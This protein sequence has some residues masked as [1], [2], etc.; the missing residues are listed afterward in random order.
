MGQLDLTNN[1]HSHTL[2]LQYVD[3]I[4]YACSPWT[5]VS[6]CM[7]R[8]SSKKGAPCLVIVKTWRI[9]KNSASDADRQVFVKKLR[10]RLFQW[11]RLCHHPFITS[12]QESSFVDDTLPVVIMPF[13]VHGNA[14]DFIA[15]NPA[16]SILSL[17]QDVTSGLQYM[18]GLDPPIAHGTLRA[19]NIL[20]SNEGKAC[21]TDPC[22]NMLPLPPFWTIENAV[23]SRWLAPE[24]LT[25]GADELPL[26]SP[27][28]D[29]YSFSMTAV[30]MYTGDRP[31]SHIKSKLAVLLKA[32]QGK[33][34]LRPT[35]DNAPQLTDGM[36][37]VLQRCWAHD[38]ASRP[39]MTTVGIWL[40]AMN[41]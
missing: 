10:N 32:T 17:L 3:A 1:N 40:R 29:V 15:E 22:I 30:E 28:G 18:H 11:R 23:Y 9:F 27:E 34:P 26:A 41:V 16:T 38:P 7:F 33:R 20:I 19:S 35:A 39:S 25:T 2:R 21:I 12:F 14:L 8:S 6:R 13:F 31:F 4:P 37:A 36:W 24:I 5:D